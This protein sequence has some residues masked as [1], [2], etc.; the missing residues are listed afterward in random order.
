[1]R[2]LSLI[3]VLFISSSIY[4]QK[5]FNAYYGSLAVGLSSGFG[6]FGGN[7]FIAKSYNSNNPSTFDLQF[8]LYKN[9]GFGFQYQHGESSLKST[10]YVGNSSVGKFGRAGVYGCYYGKLGNKFLIVPRLGTGFIRLRNILDNSANINN[11]SYDYKTWGNFYTV[12][13]D[14]NY[15]VTKGLSLFTN[16]D[17]SYLDFK[18]VNASTANGVSYNSCNYFGVQLGVKLWAR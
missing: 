10:E 17:Y 2:I 6:F 14:V 1:M 11:G 13:T 16:L 8:H 7:N 12:S 15:F 3:I 4:S 9:Y 5:P 18:G